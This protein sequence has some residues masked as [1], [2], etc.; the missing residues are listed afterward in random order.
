VAA[1]VLAGG[2]TV[3]GVLAPVLA[4]RHAARVDAATGRARAE[5]RDALVETVEGLEELASRDAVA[6]LAVP[7]S[8]SGALSRLQAR[9]ARSAVSAAALA[10]LG[11]GAAVTLVAVAAGR[12]GAEAAAVLLL[13]AVALGEPVLSLSDAAVARQRAA[14]A[15]DRLAAIAALPPTVAPVPRGSAVGSRADVVVRGLVA[16]WH[17]RP[18]LRG[19]DLDLPAGARVAVLGASGSGKST[20]AA[21]LVRFLDPVAGSVTLGGVDVRALPA[22]AVRRRI[23]LVGDGVDHVFASTVRENLRLARPDATDTELRAAL[24]RVRL[25]GWLQSL[26]DGLDT[27]LGEGASTVSGG[28]Q[29]RLATARALLADPAVLILDEPTEGLDEDTAEALMADLL[30]AASERTVLLLTHRL[31]GLD[32][33]DAIHELDGGRLR[34]VVTDGLRRAEA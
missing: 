1:L 32:R 12:H 18:A 3:S 16:G 25:T 20:V 34:P 21:V 24:E 23:A 5:L 33:V 7:S 30:D 22:E 27:W 13:T 17:G 6:A 10:H 4:A 15:R 2:V 19:L 9:A 26:P 11:W 28:Q 8:R 29:R 14:G 31:D